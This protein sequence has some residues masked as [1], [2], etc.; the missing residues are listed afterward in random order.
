LFKLVIDSACV[1]VEQALLDGWLTFQQMEIECSV[2]EESLN[3]MVALV[4]TTE[5]MHA[6]ISVLVLKVLT[7]LLK[8]LIYS[9]FPWYP[10]VSKTS[11]YPGRDRSNRVLIFWCFLFKNIFFGL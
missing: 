1:Y 10:Q 9:D 8:Y 4:S 11:G 3:K 2:V 7:T 5:H 6:F